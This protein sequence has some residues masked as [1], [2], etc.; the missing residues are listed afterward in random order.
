MGCCTYQLKHDN[1]YHVRMASPK[2]KPLPVIG[3]HIEN[4][5][6]PLMQTQ[7][8]SPVRSCVNVLAMP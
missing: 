3:S 6:H 4:T 5:L 7:P 1:P 2:P 8:N